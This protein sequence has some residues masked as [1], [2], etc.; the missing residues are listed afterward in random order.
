MAYFKFLKN[1]SNRSATPRE[2]PIADA[3]VIEKGEI[4][5]LSTAGLVTAIGNVDQDDPVLGVAAHA[6]ANGDGLTIKVYDHPD[7][8]FQIYSTNLL[9][10]TGGSTT[11]FV[12]DGMKSGTIAAHVDDFFNGSKIRIVSCAAN[13]ALNGKD[14]PVTDFTAATGTFTLGETLSAALAA[15]DTAYLVPGP[16]TKTSS[17]WNL[18]ADGTDIDWDQGTTVGQAIQIYG[19]DVDAFLTFVKLRLHKYG[20]DGAAK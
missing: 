9:T 15:G 14:V 16:G 6:H 17:H 19:S 7:D 8:I 18:T 13:S 2:Y 11:T 4:V 12:V 10:A 20:N 1:I 5:T 3:T